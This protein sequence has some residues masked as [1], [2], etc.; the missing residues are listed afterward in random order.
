V[1]SGDHASSKEGV[2]FVRPADGTHGQQPA[3]DV[4]DLAPTILRLL[5]VS[6]HHLRG[7]IIPY[8]PS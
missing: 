1:R 3:V 2:L 5:G 7:R 8:L 4:I 6:N